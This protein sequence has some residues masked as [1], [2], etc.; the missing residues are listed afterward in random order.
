MLALSQS[1]ALLLSHRAAIF[2]SVSSWTG[3]MSAGG[4]TGK[5]KGQTAASRYWHLV[6]YWR[7][8]VSVWEQVEGREKRG[9]KKLLAGCLYPGCH[10]FGVS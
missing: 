4:Q 2:M 8:P 10:N 3:S 9:Q 5:K 6:V 1:M 7:F